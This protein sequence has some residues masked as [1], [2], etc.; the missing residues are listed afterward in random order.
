VAASSLQPCDSVEYVP[1]G[2][3][4][5]ESKILRALAQAARVR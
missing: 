5:E 1:L 2:H 4:R 3:G